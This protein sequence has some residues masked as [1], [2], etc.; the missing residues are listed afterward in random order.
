MEAERITIRDR[1]NDDIDTA[2]TTTAA[3][4][5]AI[6]ALAAIATDA[7]SAV[8]RVVHILEQQLGKDAPQAVEAREELAKL[9]QLA[10]GV[11]WDDSE[12]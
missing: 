3:A 7:L 10:M 1:V 12:A 8:E 9:T 4:I 11:Q 6:A 2:A 5:A